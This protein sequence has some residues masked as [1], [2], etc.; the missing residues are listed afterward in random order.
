[1]IDEIYRVLICGKVVRNISDGL[2]D[3]MLYVI[4][5]FLNC[6]FSDIYIILVNEMVDE[7]E[8]VCVIIKKVFFDYLNSLGLSI[9]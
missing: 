9:S 6:Y 8:F 4:V 3:K 5:I 2:I 7:K 1:M